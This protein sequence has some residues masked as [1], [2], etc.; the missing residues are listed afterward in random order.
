MIRVGTP[1]SAA[2]SRPAASGRFDNTSTISMGLSEIRGPKAFRI[3]C[4]LLPRPE[5]STA[6]PSFPLMRRSGPG[7][8][9]ADDAAGRIGG[10]RRNP[11]D[12][13]HGFALLMQDGLHFGR[14]VRCHD[15][16]HADAA[17]E[18]AAHLMGI[19]PGCCCQPAE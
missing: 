15:E 18:G 9:I 19:D 7:S 14:L 5:I 3:A 13:K 16:N 11:A 12:L 1:A 10:P 17:I 4:R 2:R 6:R 8:R